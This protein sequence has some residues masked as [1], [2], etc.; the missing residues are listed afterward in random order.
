MGLKDYRLP[1]ARVDLP[2]E[3]AH[4]VVRGLA[5]AD[6][7]VLVDGFRPQLEQVFKMVE[8]N[9]DL[10]LDDGAALAYSMIQSFPALVAHGIALAA[11]EPDAADVVLKL[12][13]DTQVDALDQIGRLTFAAG[14]GPK[15]VMETVVTVLKGSREAIDSLQA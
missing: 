1:T 13:L 10:T 4:I 7:T 8:G 12:P 11:D 15:K 6:I 9:P 14:N 2:G 5:L 3:D